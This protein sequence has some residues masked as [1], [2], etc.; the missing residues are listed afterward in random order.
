MNKPLIQI[1]GEVREMTDSEFLKWQ[2]DASTTTS[3]VTKEQL[4]AEV[5][6][7]ITKIEALS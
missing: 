2:D 5:Q 4:L 6:A 3:T 1:D 7:L